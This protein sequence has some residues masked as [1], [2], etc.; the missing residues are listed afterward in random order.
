MGLRAHA[1]QEVVGAQRRLVLPLGEKA[2]GAGVGQAAAAV[3]G[4]GHPED[5]VEVAQAAHALLDV[6]LLDAHRPEDAGVALGHVRAEHLE[7]GLARLAVAPDGVVEGPVERPEDRGVAGHEARLGEG[8]ARVEVAPG[9]LEALRQGPEAVADGE[10][11]VPEELEDLLDEPSHGLGRA[12]LVQEE[13]V[14]VGERG[15]LRPPVA[16]EGDHRAPG[17]RQPRR[18]VRIREREPAGVGDD[19][20]HLVA[21]GGGD[22]EAAQAE[23]VAHPQAVGLELDESLEVGETPT[24][25]R[26]VGLRLQALAR[27]GLDLLAVDLHGVAG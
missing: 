21:A 20:V 17:E 24:G 6:R 26:R 27:V 15:E 16:A 7:K 25:F 14:H 8:G 23:A 4:L 12:A 22:L 13:E 3:A 19:L 5:R 10:A 1:E 11:D 2:R 18:R 9:F